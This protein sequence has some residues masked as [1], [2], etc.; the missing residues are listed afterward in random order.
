MDFWREKLLDKL[1]CQRAWGLREA[2]SPQHYDEN[3][4]CFLNVLFSNLQVNTF[5]KT[6]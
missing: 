5:E 2:P 6:I 3:E 4:A 1:V